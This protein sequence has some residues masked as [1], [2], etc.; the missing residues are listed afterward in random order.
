VLKGDAD[1]NSFLEW[2]LTFDDYYRLSDLDKC[3]QSHQLAN[4]RSFMDQ[5]MR[6]R[7]RISMEV[8]D[9]T[10]L[11]VGAELGKCLAIPDCGCEMSIADSDVLQ[12]LGIE[13]EH[14]K[15]PSIRGISGATGDSLNV[16]GQIRLG[17]RYGD[18][19]VF[20]DIVIVKERVGMLISWKKCLDLRAR[21]ANVHPISWQL[22]WS[23]P[24]NPDDKEVEEIK[25]RLVLEF[26]DVLVENDSSL[27]AM[28]GS[29]MRIDLNPVAIP[30]Q[31]WKA[32][33][34]PL[35][36]H[37]MTKSELDGMARKGIIEPMASRSSSW[38]HPMV[39]VKKSDGGVRLTVA[40]TKLNK[41]VRRPTQTFLIKK[42]FGIFK[43][44]QTNPQG[45]GIRGK[46]LNES[47]SM[48]KEKDPMELLMKLF[49]KQMEEMREETRRRD[50]E[51]KQREDRILSEAQEREERLIGMLNQQDRS[52]IQGASNAPQASSS[53]PGTRAINVDRPMLSCTATLSD[54]VTWKEGWDNFS[55]CQH[56]DTQSRPTIVVQPDDDIKEIIS[57][58][59]K[60]IRAQ[61][62]PLLDR[63]EFY[64][65]GQ[66]SGEPFD[67]FF[68]RLKELYA[69]CDFQSDPNC[70]TCYDRE[71]NQMR[72]MVVYGIQSNETRHKLLAEQNLSLMQEV[73][74][75]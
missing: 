26:S 32:R 19:E 55:L 52:Q 23:T 41:F 56:L 3:P 46:V 45:D 66:E 27:E 53:T 35:P 14:L 51:T 75:S 18:A 58:L 73:R 65:S 16:M 37:D 38:C 12:W 72:D 31:V 47:F 1:L 70:P 63:I 40:L 22:P 33:P 11:S 28:E 2:R 15:P 21:G 69:P 6:E 10:A 5:E 9:S 44:C 57:D 50:E 8:L 42:N 30:F 43:M 49:Q 62:N 20:D 39:V 29:P 60:Y 59:K 36:L 61:R 24:D 64:K 67:N 68:T 34:A 71:D 54:F 13:I 25:N 17:L 7:L 74:H 4:Q 48:S